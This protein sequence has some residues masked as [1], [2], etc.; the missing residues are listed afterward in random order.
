MEV[1]LPDTN[2]SITDT[3][4]DNTSECQEAHPETV[5]TMDTEETVPTD[6]NDNDTVK[7]QDGSECEML[8]NSGDKKSTENPTPTVNVYRPPVW[9]LN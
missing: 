9:A 5:Q 6:C 3:N 1:D 7:K 4:T 2:E 8:L